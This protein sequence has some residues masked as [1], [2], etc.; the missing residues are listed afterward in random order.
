MFEP[1]AIVVAVLIVAGS[2]FGPAQAQSSLASIDRELTLLCGRLTAANGAD[3]AAIRARLAALWRQRSAHLSA[4][5]ENR[6]TAELRNSALSPQ[7][8]AMA[9]NA[10]APAAA[11]RPSYSRRS[12]RRAA[13]TEPPAAGPALAPAPNGVSRNGTAQPTTRSGTASGGAAAP[14]PMPN[15]TARSTSR[16]LPVGPAD[17][18]NSSSGPAAQLEEFFPWPPPAPSGRMLLDL[19]Q[20]GGGVPPATWGEVADRLMA[21]MRRG[22]FPSWGFYTAPGGF[23]VIP[24]IEQ[25][26]DSTGV[27]LAGPARWAAETRVASTSVLTGIF[28]VRRPQGLYRAIAFVLTTDPRSGGPVTNPARM[29]EI[30]RRWGLSGALDLPE[31]MRRLPVTEDQRLFALVYEFESALGGQ[32]TVNSPGRFEI[33]HH[34]IDA[35]LV[36]R[37]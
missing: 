28:T 30:A 37:P 11:G 1:R 31:A 21:M 10:G 22:R 29:L 3:A 12:Y 18:G 8:L 19:A 16:E 9:R 17:P 25:L 6:R 23:A 13:P 7:C 34:F 27:A 24:R 2:A 33:E 32:T 5:P 4:L 20:F 15:G 36:T 35:G 26:D 14:I